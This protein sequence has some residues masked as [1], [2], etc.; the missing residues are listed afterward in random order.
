[1]ADEDNLTCKARTAEGLFLASQ[2]MVCPSERCVHVCVCEGTLL[3]ALTE[4][5]GMKDA[6]TLHHLGSEQAKLFLQPRLP[7]LEVVC[8]LRDSLEG[9]HQ[10]SACHWG[11][12]GVARRKCVKAAE[13]AVRSYYW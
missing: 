9:E 1:M 3:Q 8:R 11:V 2:A 4:G 10:T 12:Q 6:T 7:P 5:P 13:Q